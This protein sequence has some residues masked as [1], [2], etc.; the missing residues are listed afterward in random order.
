MSATEGLKIGKV[1]F[2]I[3]KNNSVVM[4][5]NMLNGDVSL[6]QPSPLKE[7]AETDIALMYEV[8]A[9][10]PMNVKRPLFRSTTA[11]LYIVDFNIECITKDYGKSVLISDA[12]ASALQEAENGT[13]NGVKIS[14][15]TLDTATEAYNKERKYYV[16]SLAFQAR[17]LL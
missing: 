17:I 16:K 14:G 3:L 1:I 2:D 4:S 10:R 7:K 9:V 12:V 8:D 15:I 5:L 13:Y 11:P 6:I